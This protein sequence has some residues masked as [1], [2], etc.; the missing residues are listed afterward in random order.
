MPLPVTKVFIAFNLTASGGNLFTL[1]DTTKGALNSAF[2]LGGDIL[3]DV[4]QYVSSVSITRGKSRELD[5]FTAGTASVVLHNE[6]RIFDPFNSAGTFFGQILPRKQIVIETNGV[7][8][9]TGYV[10]DWDFTYDISGKSFAI[11]S[12][13]DGF[14]ILSAAELSSFTTT[15]QL[16][17]TRVSTI[18][19]R[20]EVAWPIALRDIETGLSTLQSD[21]I[22]QNTNVL[23]YLQ[24]IE[25][26]ENG[27]LFMSR[28]GKVVFDSR[29]NRP[30]TT[31]V[32]FADD[33][34]ALAIPFQ[35]IT[36]MYGSENLFNRVT[37]T[38]LGGTAQTA[39]STP[40]QSAY[41]I[42]SFTVDGVLFT[43]DSESLNFANYLAGIYDEPELRFDSITVNIANL[44][45]LQS[46]NLI[47]LE[48]GDVI[49][50]KF[51]P[52]Q[53]GTQIVQYA[54][55]QGISHT[56]GIADH[57]IILNLSSIAYFPF[58]LNDPIYGVLNSGVLIY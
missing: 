1:N 45:D 31:L 29:A 16:S 30:P 20:P 58:I 3:R 13:I 50:V 49:Q 11:V 24:L 32:I 51:K 19:N 34:T 14:S 40:S 8:T 25:T 17:S 9:F 54:L 12:A 4:T 26:T 57:E 33:A 56:I 44:T 39:N 53:T 21:V 27:R 23:Q 5:R 48:M 2:V 47:N 28:D 41:G 36:V 55:V 7:R 52:N 10:D 43:S 22:P 37:V 18:L 38:R 6:S 46:A 35:N 15:S 42:S